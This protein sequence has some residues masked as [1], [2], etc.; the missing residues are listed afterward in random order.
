MSK[1]MLYFGI[2]WVDYQQHNTDLIADSK[3]TT[4]TR[5][6]NPF[7]ISSKGL[8]YIKTFHSLSLLKIITWL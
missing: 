7:Y 2:Q 3:R 1:Q 6:C 4:E 5:I 8:F